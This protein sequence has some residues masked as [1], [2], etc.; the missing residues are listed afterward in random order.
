MIIRIIIYHY[1]TLLL[2]DFIIIL[3]YFL[4]LL[5]LLYLSPVLAI[6][7]VTMKGWKHAG[8]NLGS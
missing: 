3:Q 5:L 7:V 6:K 8:W 4:L 1:Y 2:F